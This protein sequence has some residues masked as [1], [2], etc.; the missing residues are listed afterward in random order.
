MMEEIDY[1]V[2]VR[3]SG[4]NTMPLI[5]WSPA[6]NEEC[7]IELDSPATLHKLYN[8]FSANSKYLSGYRGPL[9][10]SDLLGNYQLLQAFPESGT[11]EKLP[12]EI[13]KLLWYKKGY[14]PFTG[15]YPPIA[16]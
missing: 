11:A 9:F 1:N 16:N 15:A 5:L 4:E 2:Y 8:N 10:R 6:N 3:R 7:Q 14:K 13:S 12:L